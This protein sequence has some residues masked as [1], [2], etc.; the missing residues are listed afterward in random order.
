[1]AV[2]YDQPLAFQNRKVFTQSPLVGLRSHPG[3]D[4]TQSQ[5]TIR[6]VKH[7][8]NRFLPPAQDNGSDQPRSGR[9]SEACRAGNVLRS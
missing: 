8:E 9:L 2:R 7:I 6:A 4:F 1:M 3:T 5:R